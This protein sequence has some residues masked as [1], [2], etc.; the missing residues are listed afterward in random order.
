MSLE[1]L[2]SP[3][4]LGNVEVPNRCAMAPMGLGTSMYASD[5]TWPKKT[6]RYYEERAIDYFEK[7]L[8][9]SNVNLV[10]N[11]EVTPEL[12]EKVNLDALVIAIGAKPLIPEI[13]GINSSRVVTAIEVL[14][15]ISKFKKGKALVIGGGDGGCETACYMADNGF[16]V[17][18]VEI[19]SKLLEETK[20][21]N[22]KL[23]LLK[24][25]QERNIKV[26]TETIPNKVIDEGL[27]VILANGKEF[28]IDADVIAV[29]VN[30]APEKDY[31]Q[32]LKLKA[33][34]FYIIG[35]CSSVGKI[36]DAIPEGERVGRW[37]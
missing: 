36:K 17:S 11:T 19:Q 29:A 22:V 7:E 37:I 30:L 16:D 8:K 33:E 10:L 2:F 21:L 25:I 20:D 15:D 23:P 34:E 27:E 5:E 35:D 18:I 13:P 9:L 24:L 3:I 4:K 28:G 26:Y 14:R 12:V 1:D 31:I 6:I 32:E